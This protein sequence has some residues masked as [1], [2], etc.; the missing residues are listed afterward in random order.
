M[1]RKSRGRGTFPRSAIR[2]LC[3]SFLTT[4]VMASAAAAQDGSGTPRIWLVAN[5]GVDGPSCGVFGSPCRSISQAISI[6]SAGDSIIVGPGRYGDLD[7]NGVL[8]GLGEETGGCIGMICVDKAVRLVSREGAERT[9]IDATGLASP[10]NAVAIL[11]DD[12]IFGRSHRGFTV[13]GAVNIGVLVES[14]RVWIIDNIAIGNRA[15]GFGLLGPAPIGAHLV[16]NI[17]ADNDQGFNVSGANNQLQLN[18]AHSST[19]AGF[20][21]DGVGQ[22]LYDNNAISNAN[23]VQILGGNDHKLVRNAFIGNT[24]FG[25][26]ILRPATNIALHRNNIFGNGSGVLSTSSSVV[27]ATNNFWGSATGPG[28]DPADEVSGAVTFRPFAAEP[29]D[30]NRRTH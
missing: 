2:T 14:A 21:L 27:S 18:V 28:S 12:V 1:R 29:F 19:T 17:A 3:H 13:R 4:L 5:N 10:T 22:R 23:G 9:V 30:V 6:A 7:Q 15:I 20:V 24:Q 26:H 11:A 16:G 8:G 25:V